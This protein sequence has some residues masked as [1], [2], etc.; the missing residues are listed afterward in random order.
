MGVFG[1]NIHGLEDQYGK[2]AS[3]GS[4][5]FLNSD[6]QGTLFTDMMYTIHD[7]SP[8]FIKSP[9]KYIQQNITDWIE[10]AIADRKN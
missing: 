10:T 8:I 6:I 7:A 2:T 1:I 4:S 9:Y 3:K 5:P